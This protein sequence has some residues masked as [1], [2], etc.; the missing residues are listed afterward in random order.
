MLMTQTLRTARAGMLAIAACLAGTVGVLA[1]A[2]PGTLPIAQQIDML[3]STP[4][5]A[6]RTQAETLAH[7]LGLKTFRAQPAKLR[8]NA[9]Q[10]IDLGTPVVEGGNVQLALTQLAIMAGA[11]GQLAVVRAQGG[12][13]SALILRQ[14][15]ATLAAMADGADPAVFALRDGSYH[16]DRPLIIWSGAELKIGPDETLVMNQNAGAFIIS[17][18]SLTIDG[19]NVRS[20]GTANPAAPEFRPFVLSA[21]QGVLRATRSTFTGLGMAESLLFGG[22][23]VASPGLIRPKTAVVVAGNRFDD[24]ARLSFVMTDG[25][26]VVNNHLGGA[27]GSIILAGGLGGRI[28]ANDVHPAAARS[29]IRITNGATGTV[30]A[31]NLVANGRGTGILVDR[32]TADVT[33][34]GNIVLSN[35][36]D[37]MSLSQAA[38][39]RV[40]NNMIVGNGAV[41]LRLQ[42]AAGA[43]VAGNAILGN[44]TVGFDLQSGKDRLAGGTTLSDNVV[45]QNGQGLRG[46]HIGHVV[47]HNNTLQDQL[48]R[49]F[50]GDFVPYLPGYLTATQ[51][52]DQET[53]V[54]G[55]A[56]DAPTATCREGL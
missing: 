23:A 24:V 28:E 40:I 53:F 18:G 56:A 17:F 1:Q 48:P 44:G 16:L 47:L 38:C 31:S 15:S 5:G 50:G 13:T 22:V 25:A 55:K 52:E 37:G 54:I 42:D 32:S 19:A 29:G 46:Q 10:E 11:N 2:A 27:A 12:D 49:L 6:M 36:G 26:Q 9:P 30:V 34:D 21:G 35:G 39:A 33:L 41:G 45:A 4:P 51:H 3:E 8:V 7:N 43:D 20:Y 14:G